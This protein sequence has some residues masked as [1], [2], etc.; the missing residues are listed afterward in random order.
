MED[1]TTQEATV[2]NQ[3]TQAEGSRLNSNA[4]AENIN[5]DSPQNTPMTS[6]SFNIPDEYKEAGWAGKINS[7]DDLWKQHANA[8]SLI[9][10]KTIGIPTKDSSDEEWQD[11]NSKMAPADTKYDFSNETPQEDKDFYQNMFIKNGI[12]QKAGNE[13]I[14]GFNEYMA[15]K[16]AAQRDPNDFNEKAEKMFGDKKVLAEVDSVINKYTSEEEQQFIEK[17]FTNDQLLAVTKIINSIKIDYGI[18]L[19]SKL[20][21]GKEEVGSEA[22]SSQRAQEITK[23]YLEKSKK[24]AMS[25]EEHKHYQNAIL[26]ANGVKI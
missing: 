25:A 7:V 8:Q 26:K 21:S 12:N 9:G 22:P 23:E 11:F 2:D 20:N 19:D 24:G 6:N 5:T 10:K 18:N 14:K 13:I 15:S 16:I 17:S 1:T 4:P 3:A